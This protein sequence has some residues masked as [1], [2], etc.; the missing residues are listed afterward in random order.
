M[1][2]SITAPGIPGPGRSAAPWTPI[3]RSGM[4]PLS[5]DFLRKFYDRVAPGIYGEFDGPA[6]L[7]LVAPRPLLVTT[8]IRIRG[9]R[10]PASGNAWRL[11]S[12]RIVRPVVQERFML[13]LQPD[14]G[15]EVTPEAD[16]AALDWF[17]RWLKPQRS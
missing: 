17:V 8:A 5:A 11:R 10:W 2:R 1:G 13:H 3:E 15:H 14:A 7:P 4:K 16:A 12:A 9:R 6:L